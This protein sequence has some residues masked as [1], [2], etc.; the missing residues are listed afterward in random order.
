VTNLAS[1]GIRALYRV[2]EQLAAHRQELTLIA[3][4]GSSVAL[5]L[6]LVHLPHAA[7]TITNPRRLLE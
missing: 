5:V 3:V 7:D 1:A 4:P 6:E 2:R